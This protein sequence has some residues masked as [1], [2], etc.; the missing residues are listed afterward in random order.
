MVSHLAHCGRDALLRQPRYRR[1]TAARARSL[2]HRHAGVEHQDAAASRDSQCLKRHVAALERGSQASLST[3][4]FVIGDYEG[5]RSAHAYRCVYLG[6]SHLVLGTPS[7][8]PV[9]Q[10]TAV[11]EKPLV[12]WLGQ[13]RPDVL[14]FVHHHS[15]LAEFD[16]VLKR[17]GIRAPEDFGS[18]LSARFWTERVFP[19]WKPTR[20]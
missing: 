10:L 9:L 19:A 17:N 5:V 13:Y 11:E 6:W 2:C 18:R 1:G 8:I 16:R 12:A 15:M 7:A 20:V 3:T 14:L 4:W